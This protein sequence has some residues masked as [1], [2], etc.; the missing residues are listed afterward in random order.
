MTVLFIF[1][2]GGIIPPVARDLHKEHIDRVVTLAL[3][4]ANVT[5][6]VKLLCQYVSFQGIE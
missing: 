2:A 4:Q 5:L 6:K 3:E 1:R